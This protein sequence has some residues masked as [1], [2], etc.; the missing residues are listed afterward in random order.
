[1]RPTASLLT[2]ALIA[3]LIA[4]VIIGHHPYSGPVLVTLGE[5]HGVHMAD[6][7]LAAVGFAAIAFVALFTRRR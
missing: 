4:S 6:V 2:A 3:L 5:G 1:M 7:L